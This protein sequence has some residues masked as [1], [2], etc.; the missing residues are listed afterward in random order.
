MLVASTAALAMTVRSSGLSSMNRRLTL[1]LLQAYT[2]QQ[3]PL[4]LDAPSP[5]GAGPSSYGT[6][7]RKK[8][9]GHEIRK[10]NRRDDCWVVIDGEVWE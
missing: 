3:R 6:E 5:L 7:S 4:A 1:L 10:H 8:Y 9:M 2:L